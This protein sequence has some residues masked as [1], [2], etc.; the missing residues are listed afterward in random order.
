MGRVGL[1][2]LCWL[3]TGVAVAPTKPWEEGERAAVPVAGACVVPFAGAVAGSVPAA[4]TATATL[5]GGVEGGLSL[6]GAEGVRAWASG[7]V[8]VAAAG[9]GGKGEEGGESDSCCLC[10]AVHRSL[11]VPSL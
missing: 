3:G 1:G 6:R 5:G 11:P 2:V 10:V 8:A 4:V 9:E 7:R